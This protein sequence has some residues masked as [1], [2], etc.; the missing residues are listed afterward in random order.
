MSLGGGYCRL[1]LTFLIFGLLVGRSVQFCVITGTSATI[2]VSCLGY[3]VFLL[4]A[5]GIDHTGMPSPVPFTEES[6][7]CT[8][9]EFQIRRDPSKY[10][11]EEQLDRPRFSLVNPHLYARQIVLVLR[12]CPLESSR[13]GCVR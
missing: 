1:G 4:N 5:Y 11:P 9:L 3:V 6:S 13:L 2:G 10:G 8:T 12:G 7:S